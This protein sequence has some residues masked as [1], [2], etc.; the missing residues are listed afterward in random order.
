[1]N[2]IFKPLWALMPFLLL[3]SSL[4]SQEAKTIEPFK[5]GYSISI[6]K[7]DIVTLKKAKEAGIDYIEL[8]ALSSL[9][10][11]ET[12]ELKL[13]KKELENKMKTIKA[14]ADEAGIKI[15][16]LHMPFG[17]YE[18]ISLGNEVQRKK[19]VNLH[20]EIIKHA[21]VLKPQ[22]ILFH[23][24]W[25]LGLNERELRK[26]QMIKSATELNKF[27]KGIGA[28]MVIENM[29]GPELLKSAQQ[30]RPLC[31][32]VEEVQEI[33]GRL[34]KDIYAAV[35]MNHIK[36]P[37]KLINALGNRLKSVHIADG[38]GMAERHYFP[39]SGKGKNDWNAIFSALY[40]A[41]YTGAFMYESAYPSLQ[42]LKSCFDTLYG[43]YVSGLKQ[44]ASE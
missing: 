34:P 17:Q 1:M 19:V 38:D 6:N 41:G 21:A 20:K 11:K 15:W 27:V 28:K 16:S 22:I 2:C 40:K 35:D 26:T 32:S 12:K 25:Y 42:E 9:I 29:L 30:E 10:D 36:S 18:D 39:C 7:I 8:A 31:R 33:M 5:I 24:S 14:T 44:A 4:L 3:S 43:N 23:P 37:E 13:T